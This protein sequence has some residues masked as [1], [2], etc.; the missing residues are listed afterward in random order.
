MREAVEQFVGLLEGEQRGS[1]H[2]VAAYRNDLNQFLTWAVERGLR[3][4][5]EVRQQHIST[6]VRW[7]QAQGYAAST[8]A[9]KL[10]AVRSF[11]RSL[12]QRGGLGNDPTIGVASPPVEKRRPRI[13]SAEEMDRL[14]REGAPGQSPKALR[15]RALLSL[16]CGTGMRASEVVCL[17]VDDVDLERGE[18]RCGRGSGAERV[19]RLPPHTRASLQTYLEKGRPRLVATDEHA[20]FVNVRGKSLSR[21]GLWLVVRKRAQEAGIAGEVTPHVLRHSFAVR[22]L[23][24]GESME[25]VQRMLGHAH[26]SATRVYAAIAKEGR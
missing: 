8:V 23:E 17:D 10:S 15:D 16:L 22:R 12:I 14:L 11:F 4:W 9:R 21:Q 13:L 24:E 18:V 1:P 2:T 25:E 7:L 20:L 3:S 6:F 26:F 19:I 5:E